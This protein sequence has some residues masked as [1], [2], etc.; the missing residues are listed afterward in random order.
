MSRADKRTPRAATPVVYSDFDSS[1]RTNPVTGSLIRITNEDSI[2][3]SIRNLILASSGEWAHHPE[4]GSAIYG[5]LFEPMDDVTTSTIETLVIQS[6]QQ[7]PRAIVNSVV[8]DPD[9]VRD[10]YEVTISFTPVN[11][12]RLSSV[13]LI[14]KRI[15]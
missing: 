12:T 10:L 15:R 11:G 14:L 5:M 13:S 6:L 9:P 8:V 7:E 2:K 4:I 3:Q 1:F